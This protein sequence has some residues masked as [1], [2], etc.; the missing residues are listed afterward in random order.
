MSSLAASAR[1]ITQMRSRRAT[2]ARKFC[3]GQS[4]AGSVQAL[5]DELFVA[6]Q[7]HRRALLDD[8]LAIFLKT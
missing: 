4:A 8:Q 5:E 7:V 3:P 6:G 2:A 1:F